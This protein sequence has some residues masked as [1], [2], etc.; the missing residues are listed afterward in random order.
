VPGSPFGTGRRPLSIAF[1]P[2]GL[3]LAAANQAGS[4]VSVFSVAPPSASISSPASGGVYAPDVTVATRFSCADAAFAPGVASCIDSNGESS[5]SGQLDT[6]RVGRHTYTVTATSRDT[7]TRAARITYTVA[8]VPSVSIASPSSGGRYKLGHKV[9]ARYSCH[10]GAGGPGIAF[11]KGAYA[12][13]KPIDTSRRGRHSFTVRA[14]SRDGQL[15]TKT[16]TYTVLLPGN[17]NVAPP[18]RKR[19]PD[20]TFI[21]SVKVPGPGWVDVLVTASKHDLATPAVLLAPARGRFVFARAAGTTN[22]AT[23]LRLG[24]SPNRGGRQLVAHHRS[25]TALRLWV[26]YTPRGARPRSVGYYGLRLPL[27]STAVSAVFVF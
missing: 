14:T 12:K 7:Q 3:L 2:R 15:T 27:S 5:G 25:G 18:H 6:S 11:C 16:V 24:V 4:T 1:S 23:T 10:E 9:L 17:Q 19:H 8:A 20:G 26:T 21:V 22:H 13:G